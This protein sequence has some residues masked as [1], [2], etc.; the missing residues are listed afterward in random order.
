MIFTTA[1]GRWMNISEIESLLDPNTTILKLSTTRPSTPPPSGSLLLYNRSV[2]RNYKDD[3]YK[4]IKKRNSHKVREDHVKLRVGGKFRVSGCYVHGA[5]NPDLHRRAYHLLDPETGTALHPVSTGNNPNKSPSLVLVHYLDTKVAALH[6]ASLINQQKNTQNIMN[7]RESHPFQSITPIPYPNNN[8]SPRTRQRSFDISGIH[9][10]REISGLSHDSLGGRYSASANEEMQ[11][12]YSSSVLGLETL[13][14][15]WDVIFAEGEDKL[16]EKLEESLANRNIPENMLNPL[17]IQEMIDAKDAEQEIEVVNETNNESNHSA[18]IQMNEVST[19]LSRVTVTPQQVGSGDAMT[20]MANIVD[21]TPDSSFINEKTNIVISCSEPVSNPGS[22]QTSGAF[23]WH[24]LVTFVSISKDEKNHPKA[25]AIDLFPLTRLNPYTCKCELPPDSLVPGDRLVIIVAVF[26]ES[27]TDPLCQGVAASI[28]LVLEQSWAEQIETE[29]DPKSWLHLSSPS[30]SVVKDRPFIKLLSQM[31]QDMHHFKEPKNI[32]ISSENSTSKDFDLPAPPPEMAFVATALSDFPN[33]PPL[34]R[35]Q[36]DEEKKDIGNGKPPSEC[37]YGSARSSG[38]S[39]HIIKDV[40]DLTATE[41]LNSS[42]SGKASKKRTNSM[43]HD[44][45]SIAAEWA[46]KPSACAESDT[47]AEEVDRHCK[48]RFVERLTDVIAET[49]NNSIVAE[50]MTFKNMDDSELDEI[51]DGLL[52]RIVESLVEI[53]ASSC[54]IQDELNAP[55]KSG[56]TLLHYAALYNLPSLIP[57]LL[58][59]GANPD[60]QTTRGKLTPLHLACGAGNVAI[61]DLLIRHGSALRVPDSFGLFPAHH[62]LR[63]GFTNVSEV[64]EAQRLKDK[65][66]RDISKETSI[67]DTSSSNDAVTSNLKSDSEGHE[68]E[69]FLVKSAFA[70]LSLKDKLIF[71]MMVRRRGKASNQKYNS[72]SQTIMEGEN[73]SS[74][75]ESVN[76]QSQ[77]SNG[78]IQ[79]RDADNLVRKV[80]GHCVKVKKERKDTY[81]ELEVNSVESVLTNTDKESLDIAMK[82]MNTEELEDIHDK[83]ADNSDDLT[84]WVIKRNYESLMETKQSLQKT[85][86]KHQE[87][88]ENKGP[89]TNAAATLR[90]LKNMKSQAIAG[91]VIRKNVI[92]KKKAGEAKK[93]AG[94]DLEKVDKME[95]DTVDNHTKKTAGNDLEKVDKMETDTVDNHI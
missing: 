79:M 27:G 47:K 93:T 58:S 77:D 75:H 65:E 88:T 1:T 48:I 80:M 6:S 30:Y 29:S 60:L 82:L 61:V 9:H 86:T 64:L 36:M 21:I 22:D 8:D 89:N 59:R 72:H 63:N 39:K 56:F 43:S 76:G 83:S 3:G 35:P 25:G 20:V 73:E 50:D 71:N 81:D 57:V 16:E 69:K 32:Q 40:M 66:I 31:S 74:T 18:G 7:K 4:W 54:D 62:A 37:S 87:K 55:D 14:F 95:T 23:A 68:Q 84:K 70:N 15:L 38:E 49:E 10:Q 44:I 85:L 51:L 46:N 34:A 45:P 33:P 11:E 26:L 53:S 19:E 41:D 94:K 42:V 90:S 78:D 13:D 2:T 17:I 5:E 12:S 52:V 28:G 24:T 67:D 92:K 91:L